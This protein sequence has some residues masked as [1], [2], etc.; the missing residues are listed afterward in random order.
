[1]LLYPLH[2]HTFAAMRIVFQYFGSAN[3]RTGSMSIDF[4]TLFTT[5]TSVAEQTVDNRAHNN[6]RK[7]VRKKHDALHHALVNAKPHFIEEDGE[8]NR[9]DQAEDDPEEI[10]DERIFY[11]VPRGELF[12]EDAEVPQADEGTTEYAVQRVK[13]GKSHPNSAKRQIAQKEE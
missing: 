2:F 8:R 10:D 12:E 11:H 7:E 3:Q 1:M 13:I 4:S 9:N 6:P 5:P